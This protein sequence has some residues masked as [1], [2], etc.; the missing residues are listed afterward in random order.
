M[1]RLVIA[2]IGFAVAFPILLTSADMDRRHT[3]ESLATIIAALGCV[4]LIGWMWLAD[5]AHSSVWRWLPPFWP[6]SR[7]LTGAASRWCLVA[8]LVL[9]TA[10][11]IV[12]SR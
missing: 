2:L 11:G 9:G 3:L 10:L 1:D 4:L 5:G 6:W 8:F 7:Y 12:F